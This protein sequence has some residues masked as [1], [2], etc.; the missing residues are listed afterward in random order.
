MCLHYGDA[1]AT[2]DSVINTIIDRLKQKNDTFQ[3][4]T[5]FLKPDFPPGSQELRDFQIG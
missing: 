4:P 3:G 2:K 5:S 1:H